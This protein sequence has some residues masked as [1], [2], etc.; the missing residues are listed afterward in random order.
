M[1]VMG[2]DV[3]YRGWLMFRHATLLMLFFAVV[4]GMP[5]S[6]LA[7]SYS[8]TP[9]DGPE[10]GGTIAT[11]INDAGEIVGINRDDGFVLSGNSFTTFDVPGATVTHANGI[12]D[13]GQIVGFF[14]LPSGGGQHAF[15]RDGTSITTFDFPGAMPGTTEAFGINNA[16]Q[17][18]G[19]Y[20]STVT[21]AQTAFLKDG[22]I[23]TTINMPGACSNC[24][25]GATDIANNGRIVGFFEDGAP[26]PPWRHGFLIDGASF[27]IIDYPGSL[28]TNALGIN[29][30][31]SI[32][33]EFGS[34]GPSSGFLRTGSTF[35]QIQPPDVG[36][37]QANGIN[38]ARQIVGFFNDSTGIIHGYLATP[39]PEPSTLLLLGSGLAGLGGIVWRKNRKRE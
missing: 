32:V 37:S 31:G 5:L 28:G 29:D 4:F 17:I 7:I 36:T 21:G 39:V 16:G 12:N 8:F 15:L 22:N 19:S 25:S 13:R 30:S 24:I 6:A 18:V 1:G 3:E 9:I 33:G 10:G 34:T 27:T 35:F 23:F 20:I 26:T 11:G 38:N 14:Q 2:K